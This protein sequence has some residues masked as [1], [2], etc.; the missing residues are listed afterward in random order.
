MKMLL[1]TM[2]PFPLRKT[3]CTHIKKAN[4]DIPKSIMTQLPLTL[5]HIALLQQQWVGE[6]DYNYVGNWDKML[7][8]SYE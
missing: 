1:Q 2:A 8:N 7:V 5:G 6:P 4:F 3:F